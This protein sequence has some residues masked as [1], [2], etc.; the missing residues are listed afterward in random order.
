MSG[1]PGVKCFHI[2][3]TKTY[4]NTQK[5]TKKNVNTHKRIM[6]ELQLQHHLSLSNI[7]NHSSVVHRKEQ[8]DV[9]NKSQSIFR[10]RRRLSYYSDDGLVADCGCETSSTVNRDGKQPQHHMIAMPSSINSDC[11]D[12]KINLSRVSGRNGCNTYASSRRQRNVRPIRAL[13]N[14]SN[15]VEDDASNRSNTPIHNADALSAACFGLNHTRRSR[16]DYR[17]P[18]LLRLTSSRCPPSCRCGVTPAY[19]SPRLHIHTDDDSSSTIIRKASPVTGGRRKRI[20]ETNCS[21]PT[22]VA[23]KKISKQILVWD[24]A[25]EVNDFVASLF[26]HTG[27]RGIIPANSSVEHSSEDYCHRFQIRKRVGGTQ[28]FVTRIRSHG[29]KIT[30]LDY[31]VDLLFAA[32]LS[33]IVIH[34]STKLIMN[35][36]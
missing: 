6:R 2:R 12:V 21:S 16:E 30:L 27:Y 13:S 11:S 4:G 36:T 29:R 19:P 7:S 31:A 23:D 9:L 10:E 35:D 17:S 18:I 20:V 5:N 26:R 15:M 8:R 22:S 32:I 3:S 28:Q 33:Y 24:D 1:T 25:V 34:V 14:L